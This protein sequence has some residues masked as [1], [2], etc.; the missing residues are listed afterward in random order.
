MRIFKIHTL[1]FSA[2]ARHGHSP[3][4]LWRP[5]RGHPPGYPHGTGEHSPPSPRPDHSPA[6][7][8]PTPDNTG[9]G[10]GFY[11]SGSQANRPM[12]A[13]LRHLRQ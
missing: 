4:G 9:S 3:Q 1:D 10:H 8:G 13:H 6:T 7:S 11:N 2:T 12:V 5:Q